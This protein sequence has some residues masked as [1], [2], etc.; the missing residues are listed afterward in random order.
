MR[1]LSAIL[2][3]VLVV[4][5]AS[6]ELLTTANPIGKGSWAVLGA[7]IQDSNISPSDTSL[8]LTTI[9]GYVGYGITDKLDGYLQLGS[10]SV[11]G[12]GL[13]VGIP[14][15]PDVAITGT[16]WGLNLK[17][18]VAEEGTS[19]P[20]SVAV[21]AG[22]KSMSTTTKTPAIPVY[23]PVATEDT[24]NGTQLMLG[25]GVSKIIIPFIPYGALAYKKN[26]SGGSDVST[27]LDI[28]LGSAI[29]WST[30]GAVFVE[31]TNQAI[32]PTGGGNFTSGQIAIGV[33]YK[34]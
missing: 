27:Q 18:T 8:K 12:T 4:S 3:T 11:S 1:V 9:G 13:S 16:G 15:I 24:V 30:Q 7:G 23:H 5:V 34:I 32:T 25:V 28:T 26:Q 22:Y 19:L 10:S 29:A 17:Y 2:L 33:G 20:V 6:A 21:G 14:G 31:Y